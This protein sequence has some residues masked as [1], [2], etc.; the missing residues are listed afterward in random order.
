[1][2][3][4]CYLVDSI[5]AN[6]IFSWLC[7]CYFFFFVSFEWKGEKQKKKNHRHFSKWMPEH[8]NR[9]LFVRSILISFRYKYSYCFDVKWI[10][11]T[12]KNRFQYIYVKKR[13]KSQITRMLIYEMNPRSTQFRVSSHSWVFFFFRLFI[14]L[15]LFIGKLIK[16]P[17][18]CAKL[19]EFQNT[20]NFSL[21]IHDKNVD[22]KP[23]YIFN[24]D[25]N[26]RLINCL[27]FT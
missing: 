2:H 7:R 10:C 8:A 22:A 17:L 3:C 14:W 24:D 13:M 12:V 15:A 21:S 9:L 25:G 16:C 19:T 26:M 6:E 20:A 5:N 4:C 1:M 11:I 27:P 23:F 18:N